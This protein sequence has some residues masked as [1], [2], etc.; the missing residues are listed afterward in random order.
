MSLT[1]FSVIF[2]AAIGTT[3]KVKTSS[4]YVGNNN[5]TIDIKLKSSLA[6]FILGFHNTS[7]ENFYSGKQTTNWKVDGQRPS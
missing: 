3:K 7:K 2:S 1:D 4:R 6:F 5:Y